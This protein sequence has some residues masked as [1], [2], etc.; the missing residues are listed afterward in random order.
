[1]K[2]AYYILAFVFVG[3]L[4]KAQQFDIYNHTWYLQKLVNTNGNVSLAPNNTEVSSVIITFSDREMHTFVVDNFY[5]FKMGGNAATS[6]TLLYD[7]FYY[8]STTNNCQI[9]ENCVFQND[10]YFFLGAYGGYPM[11]YEII[12]EANYLKL[13]LTDTNGNKAIY[14]SETLTVIEENLNEIKIYPNPVLTTL[15]IPSKL[16]TVTFNIFDSQ[17]KVVFQKTKSKNKMEQVFKIDF[18][19]FINGIYFL[20]IID[21][22]NSKTYQIIKK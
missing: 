3:L 5:G 12:N 10:Y 13:T 21:K 19:G 2:L 17:G 18:S 20:N 14:F 9:S 1:M 15:F 6:A 4:T 16:D 8:P 7:E 11:N 22:K